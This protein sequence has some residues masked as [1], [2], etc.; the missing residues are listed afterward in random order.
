MSVDQHS[1]IKA[2]LKNDRKA[3][4]QLYRTHADTMF[5][6]AMRYAKDYDEAS[7]VL[8]KSFIKVFR[9][10][11]SFKQEGSLEGW[12]R[13]IVVNTALESIRNL[14]REVEKRVEWEKE[15]GGVSVQMNTNLERKD[16]IRLVNTLPEKASLVLKLFAVEGFSHQEISEFLGI[17]VGTSKSQLNRA[18]NL[19]APIVDRHG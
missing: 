10:L 3:Q 16:I 18:R 8:Q 11:S 5:A 6:V 1:L 19:L 4:E 14:N 12:I 9:S 13:R 7:E 15:T 17:S 2:C